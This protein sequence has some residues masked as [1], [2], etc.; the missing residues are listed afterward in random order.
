MVRRPFATGG[1]GAKIVGSGVGEGSGPD[2]MAAATLDG[3][4]VITSDGEDVGKISD[5][6]LDVRGGRTVYAVLSSGG[7]LGMGNT[8]YAI[9]WSALT[10]DTAE[11]CFRLD[12]TA[13]RIKNARL[14]QRPLTRDVGPAVGFVA[15]RVLQPAALL[16][17]HPGRRRR[18]AARSLGRQNQG[19]GCP[20]WSNQRDS[21]ATYSKRRSQGRP[22]LFTSTFPMGFVRRATGTGFRRNAFQ[23]CSSCAGET[24][25]KPIIMGS[26]AL[27]EH[28][29]PD[30]QA[31]CTR[32]SRT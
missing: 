4:K 20:Q 23:R 25:P 21:F 6:M 10:L 1:G 5:I 2:V 30:T 32:S 26:T 31:I 8:L 9:P 19:R 22:F 29:T 15:A 7:F 27:R 18:P 28:E 12:I 24:L 17:G 13:E 3:D 16:A 14:R 11:K